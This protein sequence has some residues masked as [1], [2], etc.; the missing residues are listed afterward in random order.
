VSRRRSCIFSGPLSKR[1]GVSA[2]SKNSPLPAP[3]RLIRSIS[4]TVAQAWPRTGS[5][6]LDQ[7]PGGVRPRL[8]VKIYSSRVTAGNSVRLIKLGR[9]TR[10]ALALNAVRQ[11]GVAR[12]LRVVAQ[13]LEG[14]PQ[15]RVQRA[16]LGRRRVR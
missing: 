10:S 16:G 1:G 4:G 2:N 9:A 14:H 11:L 8:S 12:V 3:I 7:P 5:L 13:R 6:V 15:Q